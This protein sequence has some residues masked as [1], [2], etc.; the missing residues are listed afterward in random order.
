MSIQLSSAELVS[1][2]VSDPMFANDIINYVNNI[3]PKLSILSSK[4]HILEQIESAH[5]LQI[6]EYKALLQKLYTKYEKLSQNKNTIAQPIPIQKH[7]YIDDCS[8][9]T[10]K[11]QIINQV[12]TELAEIKK[13]LEQSKLSVNQSTTSCEAKD[14]IILNLEKIVQDLRQETCKGC[15]DKTDFIKDLTSKIGRPCMACSSKDEQIV[16]LSKISYKT[17]TE[18]DSSVKRLLA[19]IKQMELESYQKDSQ[20]TE[21]NKLV[22]SE[23]DKQHAKTRVQDNLAQTQTQDQSVLNELY[24]QF[25]NFI[26]ISK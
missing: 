20:L 26:S 1:R 2:I 8:S 5:S 13:E 19:Q 9:C 24:K 25:G 12:K 23:L 18:K 3:K 10:I 17:S 4:T 22:R 11:T 6:E 16:K 21:L 14:K 7:D 15:V